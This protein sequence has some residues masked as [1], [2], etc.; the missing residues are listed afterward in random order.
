MHHYSECFSS[1]TTGDYDYVKMGND[2]ACQVVGI[3]EVWL[4]TSTD[5]RIILKD[6]RHV[7]DIRLNLIFVGWLY[8]KGKIMKQHMEMLQRELDCGT[9]LEAKHII[10]DAC[11]VEPER[12]ECGNR[13]NW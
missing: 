12:G 5:C 9:C 4:L 6:M 8:D 1:Y 11:M 10:C 2:G 13:H 3:R 7:L